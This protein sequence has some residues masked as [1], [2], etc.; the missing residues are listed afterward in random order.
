[1]TISPETVEAQLQKQVLRLTVMGKLVSIDRFFIGC[2][3]LER[4]FY[5]FLDY[6]M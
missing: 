1:M 6:Y 2:V 4:L 5:N 3:P